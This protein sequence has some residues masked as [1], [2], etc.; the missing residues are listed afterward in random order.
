MGNHTVRLLAT[1]Q[2]QLYLEPA[3]VDLRLQIV[4]TGPTIVGSFPAVEVADEQP[5]VFQLPSGVIQLNKPYGHLS[6]SAEQQGSQVLP[7]WMSFDPNGTLMGTPHEGKDASYNL[8]IT[9]TDSDGARN[10]TFLMLFVRAPCPIGRYRHFRIR[11]S[12]SNDGSWYDF[13][14]FAFS[15]GRSSICQAFWDVAQPNATSFPS[16]PTNSS[17]NISGTTYHPNTAW[18]G[19]RDAVPIEAFQQLADDGCSVSSPFQDGNAWLVSTDP[20]L[21]CRSSL[22]AD[23]SMPCGLT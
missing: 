6:F 3:V 8:T 9:G 13:E 23:V 10:S 17:Y 21:H 19:T 1:D 4:G 20:D 5:L 15:L 14:P 18:I 12:A 7:G 2:S 11:I 22:S 16:L